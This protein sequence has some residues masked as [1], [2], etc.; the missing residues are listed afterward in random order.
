MVNQTIN[1]KWP[2]LNWGGFLS[3]KHLFLD[4]LTLAT[5]LINSEQF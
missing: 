1:E 2:L 5:I 4:H 3:I